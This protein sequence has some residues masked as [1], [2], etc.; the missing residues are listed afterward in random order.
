MA[1]V[2]AGG[3]RSAE[4][5]ALKRGLERLIK[6]QIR[7]GYELSIG[8]FP[9]EIPSGQKSPEA[10]IATTAWV[11]QALR[12]AEAGGWRHESLER[13]LEGIERYLTRNSAGQSSAV[14]SSP[15]V[16]SHISAS[17]S[18]PAEAAVSAAMV[19]EMLCLDTEVFAEELE[20]QTQFL[21]QDR[22]LPS[23]DN[24]GA[25]G[26]GTP[27][28]NYLAWYFASLAMMQNGVE[29]EEEK[30]YLKTLY[31]TMFLT[32]NYLGGTD[33]EGNERYRDPNRGSFS[34]QGIQE[35]LHGRVYAAALG[36]LC[37]QNA[38]RVRFPDSKRSAR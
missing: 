15:W 26:I 14:Y 18:A 29:S 34:P 2:C 9:Y 22:Y 11:A 6:L 1:E 5:D 30:T 17:V 13:V 4:R 32:G 25:F 24:Y 36:A 8:G 7:E 37:I 12:T 10:D 3:G 38:Y 23:N 28:T 16:A 33:E 20:S 27:R 31:E 21:N 35:E 19:T